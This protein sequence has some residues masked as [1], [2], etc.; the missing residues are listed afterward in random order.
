MEV[1]KILA[2]RIMWRKLRYR[3]GWLGRDPDPKWYPAGYLKNAPLALKAFH[4]ANPK[5]P[6]PPERLREWIE[7]AEEDWYVQDTD[8]DD[9]PVTDARGQASG[10][11]GGDVTAVR[12]Q[13]NPHP[14]AASFGAA[15]ASTL[16]RFEESLRMS[17]QARYDPGK[18]PHDRP[19]VPPSIV[20]TTGDHRGEMDQRQQQSCRRDDQEHAVPRF[21]GAY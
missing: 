17:R 21:T 19:H 13:I 8:E 14:V 6:G 7:A 4:D 9:I 16:H 20:R 18:T 15:P 10:E 12:N 3:V 2:S 11:G 5:A 1:E